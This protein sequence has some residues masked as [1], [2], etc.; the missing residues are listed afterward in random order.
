MSI[1]TVWDDWM[2]ERKELST[3]WSVELTDGTWV[4]QDDGRPG[5]YP[6]SAW[7][8]LKQ[9]CHDNTLGIK[10]MRISFRSHIKD[11]GKDAQAFFFCK[12]V[13]GGLFSAKNIHYYI[14]GTVQN[15]ILT[16]K[17]WEVPALLPHEEEIRDIDKYEECLIWTKDYEAKV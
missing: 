7:T 3:I 10:F 12:S 6:E 17:K 5:V 13:L 14:V 11:V 16:T 4:Y 15:G 1:C 8:R 2:Q 9:Y